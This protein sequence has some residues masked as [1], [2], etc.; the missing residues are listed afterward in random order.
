MDTTYDFVGHGSNQ[1]PGSALKC[2]NTSSELMIS[3]FCEVVLIVTE[4]GYL[5]LKIFSHLPWKRSGARF[6]MYACSLHALSK[7][8]E[9]W[10]RELV[11]IFVLYST[12]KLSQWL[13]FWFSMYACSLHALSKICEMWK[14]ELVDTLS[15]SI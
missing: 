10:K 15:G 7:I 14:R 6:C 2:Q 1:W 5:F 3:L 8:Y 9:M 12:F 11:D 13:S 4:N